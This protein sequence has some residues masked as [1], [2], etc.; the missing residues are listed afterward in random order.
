MAKKG[1]ETAKDLMA[2]LRQT[3]SAPAPIAIKPEVEAVEDD[4]PVIDAPLTEAPAH[5]PAPRPARRPAR[6][7]APRK[8]AS[9]EER[10]PRR[11]P[12]PQDSVRMSLDLDRDVQREL[13]QFALFEAE[14]DA[15]VVG[16]VLVEFLLDRPDLREDVK[17]RIIELKREHVASQQED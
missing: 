15:A 14:I 4:L 1:G 13:K 17:Q 9:G 10:L 3:G 5:T 16:R 6:P 11:I 12:A 2:R 7:K 8:T